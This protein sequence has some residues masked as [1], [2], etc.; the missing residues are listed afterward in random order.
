M[1]TPDTAPSS[2]L[3]SAWRSSNCG[4]V[5]SQQFTTV[6]TTAPRASNTTDIAPLRFQC[7]YCDDS[8]RLFGRSPVDCCKVHDLFWD[9]LAK[10]FPSLLAVK[11][12]SEDDPGSSPLYRF[13]QD[14][15]TLRELI[16]CG[17][18]VWCRIGTQL[19]EQWRNVHLLSLRSGREDDEVPVFPYILEGVE[20][21]LR[22]FTALRHLS[23]FVLQRPLITRSCREIALD[24]AMLKVLV[25]HIRTLNGT[26]HIY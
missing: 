4:Y 5:K 18:R 6:S 22:A 1:P 11:I 20:D 21:V 17:P 24:K 8:E 25:S 16:V 26:T 9:I 12:H 13:L 3:A 2:V 14:L 7:L 15:D 23:I 19:R 10:F